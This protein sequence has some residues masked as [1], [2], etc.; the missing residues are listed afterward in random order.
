MDEFTVSAKK[1]MSVVE[2]LTSS[3]KKG[4]GDFNKHFAEETLPNLHFEK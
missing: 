4:M 1:S 2:D 3:A